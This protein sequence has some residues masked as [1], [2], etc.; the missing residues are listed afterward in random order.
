MNE[1]NTAKT[2]VAETVSREVAEEELDRMFDA[3]DIE[4][5]DFE[6][7]EEEAVEEL[8]KGVM[9][10]RV[11]IHENGEPEA[12]CKL[13]GGSIVKVRFHE[14]HGDA[15]TAIDSRGSVRASRNKRGRRNN[16]GGGGEMRGAYASM[17]A[18]SGEAPATFSKMRLKDV[19]LCLAIWSL[20]LL[21]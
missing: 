13:R 4:T 19:K 3:L 20:F 14:P 7:D 6:E 16:D 21:Q 15:L 2:V 10:G 9:R 5:D 1:E 12:T 11:V 18:M 8:V 17:A